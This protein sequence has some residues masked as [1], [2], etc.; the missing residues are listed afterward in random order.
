MLLFKCVVGGVWA[1][2]KA[3]I[4]V[5]DRQRH[6]D[7]YIWDES[8]FTELGSMVIRSKAKKSVILLNIRGKLDI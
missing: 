5:R 1:E 6:K 3:L 7:Y 4:C 2:S 8:D